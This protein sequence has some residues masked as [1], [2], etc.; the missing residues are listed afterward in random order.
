MKRLTFTVL[1]L[2]AF[3][4]LSAVAADSLT[5]VADGKPRALIVMADNPSPAA[6]RALLMLQSHLKEI[7]GTALEVK[8][9]SKATGEPSSQQPCVL[10]GQSRLA[11]KLGFTTQGLGAGGFIAEA[12]GNVLAL[13]GTDTQTLTDYWGTLYATT[14]L[15]EQVGVRYLWPGESGKV[16]PHTRT[17]EVPSFKVRLTPAL[18]QRHVRVG[19]YNPRVQG[20]LDRLHF[21]KEDYDRT[22]RNAMKTSA[23]TCDWFQWQG[24]G[25]T[26]NIVGGHAFDLWWKKYG[27][28]HPEWFAL[29][30]DGTRGDGSRFCKSNPELIAAVAREKIEELNK[31]PQLLGV[32]ICPND[33]SSGATFC[34]CPKC[35]ALDAPTDQRVKLWS[36]SGKA[37]NYFDHVPLTDRMVYFWNGIAEKVAQAHPARLLTVDAYSAY[38]SPPVQRT[39]HP[40]LVVRYAA[41]DYDVE[42]DRIDGLRGWDAWAGAAKRIYFRSNLMLAGRRTGMPLLYM[43]RFAEDFRHL[44]DTG[45][46]GTDLDSCMANW[47][48]QGLNYYVVSRL[49]TEPAQNVDTLIDDYCRAGFGPA[50]RTLRRYY[51]RLESVFTAMAKGD[52]HDDAAGFSDAVLAELKELIAQARNETASDAAC[53]KRV[54]FIALGAKWTEIETHAHRL[55]AT[56]AKP[57]P[58]LVKRVLD[59][60]HAL[61]REVFEK[62]PLALNVT[63]ISFGEDGIWSRVGYRFPN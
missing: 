63:L 20:G 4:G 31:N 48:T 47:A 1:L 58:A 60:R 53:A 16:M 8:T 40:N 49:H 45:M 28:E 9:E 15:L 35:E 19:G 39:L 5:L 41:L 33:G 44:A 59:E 34:T 23:D 30:P 56:T 3:G 50:A 37:M 21:T 18:A 36:R 42:Q 54:E 24:M 52:N 6:K 22:Q 7:T 51:D 57:D 29:Q 43:H 14:R 10:L 11:G 46:M 61:M 62:E 32:S 25:G 38:A 27:T 26:L 12:R 17:L 55:L 2:T 13:I